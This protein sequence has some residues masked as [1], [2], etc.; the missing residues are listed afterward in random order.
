MRK[1]LLFVVAIILLFCP[2]LF[3][4]TWQSVPLRTLP[5]QTAGL[6]GGEGYQATWQ[7]RYAPSNHDVLYMMVDIAGVWKSTNAG[8]TTSRPTWVMK[9]TGFIANGGTSLAVHPTNENI[10]LVA[11]GQMGESYA[12]N[13]EGIFRTT[14]GGDNWTLVHP[15]AFRRITGSGDDQIVF[16]TNSIAY[17]GSNG[18]TGS[19]TS[20]IWKS[21]DIGATWARLTLNGGGPVM[22]NAVIY[23][24]KMHPT[25]SAIFYVCSSL[26]FH[27]VEDNGSYA[28]LTQLSSGF[29]SAPN[30]I[31][32]MA[33]IDKNTPTTIYVLFYNKGVYKSTNGGDSFS[34]ANIGLEARLDQGY[35]RGL[36]YFAI[37]PADPN[38]L[39]A[40]AKVWGNHLY[41]SH[42]AAGSWTQTTSM[43]ESNVDGWFCGSFLGYNYGSGISDTRPNITFHPTNKNLAYVSGF[44]ETIRRTLD[45]GVTW[46]YA[47][48]GFT[49]AALGPT[50]G[51]GSGITPVEFAKKDVGSPD[52]MYWA[53][54]DFGLY[55]TA[56]G[57]S[58]FIKESRRAVYPYDILTHN[59]I[60]VAIDRT[61]NPQIVIMLSRPTSLAYSNYDI[62]SIW[63]SRNGG[64]DFTEV[65][66]AQEQ[67]RSIRF[68]PIDSNIAYCQRYKFSN[69]LTNNSYSTLTN[70]LNGGTVNVG[71]V[72]NSAASGGQTMI[73]TASTVSGGTRIYRSVNGGVTW[74]DP[75]PLIPSSSVRAYSVSSTNPDR[76][77]VAC[78][79]EGVYRIDGGTIIQ[80]NT[81]ISIN[82][83]GR[84]DST[85]IA[86]DPN[87]DDIV[88]T[89]G[90][91]LQ[92]CHSTG[93]Y[94]ST[95]G[96][97]TWQN[98]TG[99]L[100]LPFTAL[101]ITVSPHDSYVYVGSPHGTW[102]LP[103]PDQGDENITDS[104]N[105]VQAKISL[106]TIITDGLET[107][108]AWEDANEITLNKVITG[109]TLLAGSVT[110]KVLYNSSGLYILVNIR[111]QDLHLDSTYSHDDSSAE[112]YID[113]NNTNEV[114]TLEADTDRLL[115]IGWNRNISQIAFLPPTGTTTGIVYGSSTTAAGYKEEWYIPFANFGYVGTSAMSVSPNLSL[116]FIGFDVFYNGD[117]NTGARD[118]QTGWSGT[119]TNYLYTSEYGDLV[120]GTE[121]A[122]GIDTPTVVTGTATTI[123]TSSVTLCG[124][125][126]AND[127][128]TDA[129]IEYGTESG[130]LGSSTTTSQFTGS[131]PGALSKDITG[132]S[133][134]T[135]IYYRA[136]G[137]SSAGMAYGSELS[138]T[139]NGTTSGASQIDLITGQLAR[140]KLDENTG[141][142]IN[143]SVGT[144]TGTATGMSWSSG[145]LNYSGLFDGIDD[146]ITCTDT[147][148][149]FERTSSFSIST[150]I[151]ANNCSGEQAI[152][153]KEYSS[154]TYS[155]FFFYLNPTNLSFGL[156]NNWGSPYYRI[157]KVSSVEVDNNTWRHVIVTYS[158]NSLA[159]GVNFYTDGTLSNGAT[160]YDT[161]GA[162]TILNDVN[163]TIGKFASGGASYLNGGIDDLRVFNR[164]LTA[165]EAL[166]LSV[167]PVVSGVGTATNIISGEATILG[168]AATNGSISANI[169]IQ[170]GLSSGVYTGTS[171]EVNLAGSTTSSGASFNLSG[172][173]ADTVVYYRAQI[174][175]SCYTISGAEQSFT[176]FGGDGVAPTLQITNPNSTGSATVSLLDPILIA[177][178]ASDEVA[179]SHVSWLNVEA[180]TS[181][182]CDGTTEWSVHNFPI[183][184]GTNTCKI[185]AF[186]TSNN[187]GTATFSLFRNLDSPIVEIILPAS[188]CYTSNGSPV[189]GTTSI[190]FSFSGV[191]SDYNGIG[192]VTM[193]RS[194]T[195]TAVIATGT[196]TWNLTG[197]IS[198]GV[199]NTVS[200]TGRDVP[201]E[202]Q[203]TDT[204]TMGAF[205]SPV[206]GDAVDITKSSATLTGTVTINDGNT[207]TAHFDYGVTSGGLT[208]SSSVTT[209][210]AGT[211]G[212]E[213]SVSI[214]LGGL[215]KST[216]YYYEL[217]GS[218][219]VGVTHGEELS[220][221]TLAG[222]TLEEVTGLNRPLSW[223]LIETTKFLQ[224]LRNYG[225]Y[226]WKDVWRSTMDRKRLIDDPDAEIA[227]AI[228]DL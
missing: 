15:M 49:G 108:N 107:E 132:L 168:T 63:I 185:T 227:G 89:S 72:H 225:I 214:P 188:N 51:N 81:G 130:L 50:V 112:I 213:A 64:V 32:S 205:P 228:E 136:V 65:T 26:G 30:N 48:T 123:G 70:N 77:Y 226:N 116:P 180:G 19:T 8:S 18:P 160:D 162:N 74:T 3:A 147:P 194:G 206:T 202:N 13:C 208:G 210:N 47:S 60:A 138:F 57:G 24:M 170:Y 124:T 73:Y 158:G 23:D 179:L 39:M 103:P 109:S 174:Y 41:Y 172:L 20:G 106:D 87:N 67:L 1:H 219:T 36:S 197:T 12:G 150:W 165:A 186:D 183:Q 182:V 6:S 163:F 131:T 76:I 34:S 207:T 153:S 121:T 212:R 173:P 88:Y 142:V 105:Q 94:R 135:L 128:D 140:W 69:L 68:D 134:S 11:G 120:F 9:H 90:V 191:A 54:G 195:T 33:V 127:N 181:G 156:V 122:G 45:G 59:T 192:S 176:S 97:L 193:T 190:S 31:P 83:K 154:P 169:R 146:S 110:A 58:T 159:S 189:L 7:Y 56:D 79:D 52:L 184:E 129:W 125:V 38:Y 151:K 177:G 198:S 29:P 161:L 98:I 143:D 99:N 215:N 37:S 55:R 114:S 28:T 217:V 187:Q 44:T 27:K 86:V 16:A 133:P 78:Y 104:A 223:S 201:L 139:T 62:Y 96:G 102:K 216:E 21:T 211:P 61:S 203:G 113:G 35:S 71:A 43:D 148:F 82:W 164:E 66:T 91:D 152:I 92:M 5:Q 111:D 85:C 204:I 137:S 75:F 196:S 42:N 209:F 84:Y 167:I 221:T 101:S 175:S 199:S 22:T 4:Q 53:Q 224:G 149:D 144:N 145:I 17:A 155:G 95:D 100:Q 2:T 220:F 93:V 46:K 218:G 126:T 157:R 115:R 178:I 171:T 10:V 25:N 80:A 119:Y 118:L 14:D 166:T 141:T 117:Y 222:Y 40:G 200:F